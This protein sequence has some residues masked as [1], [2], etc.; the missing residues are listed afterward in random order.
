[1][2]SPLYVDTAAGGGF[3]LDLESGSHT[4][5]GYYSEASI[6]S[7][8]YDHYDA[9]N[10]G[11][12]SLTIGFAELY[13]IVRALRNTDSI[14]W[15]HEFIAALKAARP[16]DSAAIDAL[17]STENIA[18]SEAAE[19]SVSAS[20]SSAY[21][22]QG[23]RTHSCVGSDARF[24]HSPPIVQ[25]T[26]SGADA[27]PENIV[28]NL[29]GSQ[30]CGM[31]APAP[32]KLFGSAQFRVAPDHSGTMF[33]N[34]KRSA[35]TDNE[36][37][38]SRIFQ[39]GVELRHCDVSRDNGIC[40]QAVNAGEVYMVEVRLRDRCLFESCD[41][42]YSQL[43]T[44]TL[45][46][47]L[48]VAPHTGTASYPAAG[49]RYL[50]TTG[51]R[52]AGMFGGVARAD[53]L[54]MMNLP[55]S[56][57]NTGDYKALLVA[58]GQRTATTSP[59]CAGGCAGRQDWALGATTDYYRNDVSSDVLVGTTNA[60]AL[61][62]FPLAARV[63]RFGLGFA[64][65]WTGLHYEFSPRAFGGWTTSSYHCDGWTGGSNSSTRG[66]IGDAFYQDFQSLARTG[67][68]CSGNTHSLLC[69]QQ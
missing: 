41:P 45:R 37:P 13:A 29:H 59:D 48:P 14:I 17:L 25:V 50:F 40:T 66:T 39:R 19:S 12:D 30:W 31:V 56:L 21:T 7:L 55:G 67:A 68:T 28:T 18:A 24:L 33:I 36:R 46:I 64:E 53:E 57:A 69:V 15:I 3:Q 9:N 8:L 34:L 10:E 58:P 51:N 42:F 47:D 11:L 63:D 54:C 60:D 43:S 4:L 5:R 62:T 35:T 2:G 22:S 44:L 16:G 6:Q 23:I 26:G 38:R 61:L 20:V 65:Y 1:M 32:N 27:F 49:G 52:Y